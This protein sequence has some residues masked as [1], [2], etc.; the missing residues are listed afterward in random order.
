MQGVIGPEVVRAAVALSCS[1]PQ[2]PALD[3]LDVCLLGRQGRLAD[4]GPDALEP[5]GAFGQLMAAAF[6]RGMAP[7]DWQMLNQP[8][9]PASV[10]QALEEEWRRA[11]LRPFADRYGLV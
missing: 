7:G 2:A 6:D 11:V 4:L 3:V 5:C 8:A 10:R 9:T 1:H